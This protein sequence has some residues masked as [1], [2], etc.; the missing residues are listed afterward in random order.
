MTR[1]CIG[2]WVMAV[3]VIVGFESC[4]SHRTKEWKHSQIDS[5]TAVVYNY[6]GEAPDSARMLIDSLEHSGAYSEALANVRRAQLY[7][8][9]YQP[10][11]S[12]LYAQR[13]L[14]DKKLRRENPNVYY[15]A[16]NL[17][18]NSAQNVNNTEKA[19]AYATEAMAK[20]HA[21]DGKEAREYEPDFLSSIGLSQF[22]LNRN[23]EANKSLERAFEMYEAILVD[24][25]SFTWF[26]PEFMMTV[27][28]VTNNVASDSVRLAMG[29]LDRL[30]QSYYRTVSAKDIPPHV[31]DNCTAEFELTQARLYAAAYQFRNAARHYQAFRATDYAHTLI[32]KKSSAAYLEEVGRWNELEEAIEAADSFYKEND[33]QRT[34]DYL[35]NV[36]GK[37]FDVQQAKGQQAAALLTAQRIVQLLDTVKEHASLD[38]AAELAVLYETQEKEQMI[39]EQ[40]ADILQ[41]RW[42][43][44]AVA[45][46]LIVLFFIIYS[47]LRR[48]AA[49]HLA[50]VSAQKERIESELRI[51]RD[52]QMSMLSTDFPQRPD[53][54]LYAWMATAREVGG[55]LYDF[56][57]QSDRMYF[58]VGDVSGKGVPASLFMAQT[59][60]LFRAL[61]KQRHMPAKI[62][63]MLNDE[64]TENNDN[65]MFV[66]MFI[67]MLDLKTGC[68]DFCNAGHNPPVLDG[69]F[70]ELETN[71]P[72]GLWPKLE[73]VGEHI[74]NIKGKML[75]LYTDGLNEAEGAGRR[76]F[77]DDRL[78][79]VA[80]Q[81][82]DQ[83]V[84][85]IIGLMMEEVEKHREGA[86]PSDDLTMLCLRVF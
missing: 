58:C 71:A 34:I 46:V 6:M 43:G 11:L 55:D 21:D 7:S 36:L 57:L 20:A 18:I 49:R 32:G 35:I 84:R 77:G 38:D 80:C 83:P 13:A 65:G 37:K 33:S 76:Q 78:L 10:R 85:Q 27:D 81:Q 15:F 64:L 86:E 25:K 82:N 73:F 9:Q 26:Y 24:A 52:I 28:A 45:L 12:E 3:A 14:K 39:A 53:F 69:R 4:S 16:Y 48:R 59:L 54:D 47:V 29:W 30:Q 63:T 60:R 74:E 42:I 22:K 72:I 50:I 62:A 17:L 79:A 44:T 23:K 19:L 56:M 68:L 2:A 66:T 5:L 31:K 8:E 67:G 75:F 70:M 1:K 40:Q 51:A 61:A 41:Q